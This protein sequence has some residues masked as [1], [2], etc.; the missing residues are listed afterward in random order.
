VTTSSK[1]FS[2]KQTAQIQKQ[3]RYSYKSYINKQTKCEEILLQLYHIDV[4]CLKQELPP[5]R[6][7][8]PE[9]PEKTT[10]LPQV[11]DKFYHIML[12]RENHRPDCTGSCKYNYHTC[13]HSIIKLFTHSLLRTLLKVTL[14]TIKQTKTTACCSLLLCTHYL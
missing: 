3:Q 13:V 4:G 8:K 2:S 1:L 11:T 7:T 9:D 12:Y 5:F 6:N 10:D 14:S